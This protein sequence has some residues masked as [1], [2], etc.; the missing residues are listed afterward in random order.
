MIYLFFFV[1]LLYIVKIDVG[2]SVMISGGGFQVI[3]NID[4][5]Y[6]YWGENF[7]VGLEYMIDSQYYLLEVRNM[8]MIQFILIKFCILRDIN[9]KLLNVLY[10]EKIFFMMVF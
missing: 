3:Y 6:F 7:S 10:C 8:I 4:Q 1:L 9:I 2:Y 5:F